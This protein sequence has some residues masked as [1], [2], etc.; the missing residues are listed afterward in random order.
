MAP[1]LLRA[2]PQ[3]RHRAKPTCC[4]WTP[5]PVSDLNRRSRDS[6]LSLAVCPYKLFYWFLFPVFSAPT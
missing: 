4:C 6:L 3:P 2:R 5:L 1:V